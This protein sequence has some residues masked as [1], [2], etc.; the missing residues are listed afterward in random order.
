MTYTVTL[1]RAHKVLERIS[2]LRNEVYN[3]LSEMIAQVNEIKPAEIGKDGKVFL[4]EESLYHLKQIQVQ[5]ENLELYDE[6]IC[7]IKALIVKTN[8]ELGI[9]DL[10]AKL[11]NF[12][13]SNK[14]LSQALSSYGIFAKKYADHKKNEEAITSYLAMREDLCKTDNGTTEFTS[15]VFKVATLG[16]E[17]F[18]GLESL[19]KSR[20][21]EVDKI[22]DQISAL[23]GTKIDLPI[24]E[25]I[26]A[27]VGLVG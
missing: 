12:N 21:L 18:S 16:L 1:N 6:A 14:K 22:N 20:K 5:L 4:R 19:L 15:K 13:R 9:N 3:D 8:V 25:S 27:E 11:D 2:V 10:I 7:K 17:D 24:S 23:N 26:A